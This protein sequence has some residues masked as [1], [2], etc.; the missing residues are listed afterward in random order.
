MW[1][2]LG[3]PYIIKGTYIEHVIV[4]VPESFT[5]SAEFISCCDNFTVTW[6][7]K[8]N[9]IVNTDKY[10]ISTTIVKR[11]HYKTSL[12]VMQSGETDTGNYTVTITSVTGSDRATVSV[13]VIRKLQIASY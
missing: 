1:L 6:K 9:Y 8:N 11:C 3:Y 12:T 7:F 5:L 13:K 10:V 4:Q 2:F